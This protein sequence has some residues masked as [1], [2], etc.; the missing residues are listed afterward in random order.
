M[1]DACS[2]GAPPA[3]ARRAQQAWRMLPAHLGDNPD[4]SREAVEAAITFARTHL[5]IG[6]TGGRPC[7][8]AE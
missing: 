8:R 2:A 1:A 3:D 7:A 5:L 4:L 6:R